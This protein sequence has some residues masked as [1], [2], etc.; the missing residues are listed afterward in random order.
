MSVGKLSE[1]EVNIFYKQLS[2][3]YNTKECEQYIINVRR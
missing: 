2:T 3:G 1:A